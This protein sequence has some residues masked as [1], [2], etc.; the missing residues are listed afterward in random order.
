MQQE[1]EVGGLRCGEV[2]ALLGDFVDGELDAA[3][4]GRVQA[5]LAGCDACERFGGRYAAVVRRLRAERPRLDDA[6]RLRLD[7]RV[8]AG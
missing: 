1:R 5:H 7:R 8:R 6:A 4:V 2:L 3:T